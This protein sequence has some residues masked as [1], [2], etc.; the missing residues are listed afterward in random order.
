MMGELMRYLYAQLP[1]LIASIVGTVG[2]GML[3]KM[4][5]KHLIYISIFGF[6]SYAVYLAVLFLGYSELIAAFASAATIA[7]LSEIFARVFKAPTVIFTIV[8]IVSIVP[9][10]SLYYSMR[11]LLLRDLDGFFASLK[12]ACT[13]TAGIV[14]GIVAI[15]ALMKL[16]TSFKRKNA[17]ETE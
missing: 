5:G 2:F 13:I 9:G 17:K 15:S 12:S 14:F 8:G 10:S 6:L 3:F 16:L 7:L 1:V 4:R 11:N